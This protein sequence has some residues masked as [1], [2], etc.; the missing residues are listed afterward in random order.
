MPDGLMCTQHLKVEAEK[1]LYIIKFSIFPLLEQAFENLYSY[2]ANWLI[3]S[4]F[5]KD[6]KIT[7]SWTHT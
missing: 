5:S 1:I 2:Y 4:S 6:A 3:V 7:S